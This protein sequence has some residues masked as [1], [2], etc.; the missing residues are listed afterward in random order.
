[1]ADQSKE[2]HGLNDFMF[3]ML[4][5]PEKK[6]ALVWSIALNPAGP[7]ATLMAVMHEPITALYL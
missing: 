6:A 3:P 2:Q 5:V 4:Q 7:A 1:M